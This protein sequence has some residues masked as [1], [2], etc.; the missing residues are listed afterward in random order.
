MARL[1]RFLVGLMTEEFYGEVTIRF[2]KGQVDGQI[3]VNRYYLETT[4]P[5]SEALKRLEDAVEKGAIV[6]AEIVSMVRLLRGAD[7]AGRARPGARASGSGRSNFA[8]GD[9]HWSY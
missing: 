8:P 1:V 2:K 3:A 7:A 6:D 5:E 4:L 9:T